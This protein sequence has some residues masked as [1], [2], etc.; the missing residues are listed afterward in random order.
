MSDTPTDSPAA[1]DPG[2]RSTP[3]SLESW[4]PCPACGATTPVWRP[5]YGFLVQCAECALVRMPDVVI[6]DTTAGAYDEA[7]FQDAYADYL[8]GADEH[9][10]TARMR[11]EWMRQWAPGGNLLEIGC[12]YG[13]FLREAA[14]TYAPCIGLDLAAHATQVGRDLWGVDARAG[15]IVATR[16]P[17]APFDVICT[18]DTMEHFTDPTAALNAITHLLKPGGY[19]FFV[20]VDIE[21]RLA[22]FRGARWR[23][24]YMPTH[25]YFWGRGSLRRYLTRHGLEL[26]GH[27]TA[28]V[29]R[30]FSR[31]CQIVEAVSPSAFLR[32]T[33]RA[34]RSGLP[35]ALM[36]RIRGF[37]D[38]G[39]LILVA[40]RKQP[41]A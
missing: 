36:D 15:D 34:L 32:A 31:T 8:G 41:A 10:Q 35:L 21:S 33:S 3:R 6:A 16:F 22:R 20:T 2:T 26:M 11:L 4:G 1:R 17:E 13:L 9:V 27:R 30:T 29:Y 18:W 14:P 38:L 37:V 28:P 25:L 7:F 23:A 5:L 39:D 19:L 24:F 40:A 12:A